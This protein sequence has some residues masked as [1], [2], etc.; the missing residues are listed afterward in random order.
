MSMSSTEMLKAVKAA[1]VPSLMKVSEDFEVVQTDNYKWTVAVDI[2]GER[3]YA[4]IALSAKKLDF[5]ESNLFAEVEQFHEKQ[6]KAAEREA[7][8]AENKAKKAAKS[9]E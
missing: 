7:K 4:D 8:Q 2:N 9:A 3:H 6:A 1:V 5:D